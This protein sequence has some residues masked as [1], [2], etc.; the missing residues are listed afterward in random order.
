MDL[1]GFGQS[2]K[3]IMDYTV[4][5][6]QE[7]VVDFMAEFVDGPAVLVGNSLGSLIALAVSPGLPVT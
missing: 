7:L 6:W 2:A 5:T 1:L 4:E 3:P